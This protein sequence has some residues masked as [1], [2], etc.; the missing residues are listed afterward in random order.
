MTNSIRPQGPHPKHAARYKSQVAPLSSFKMSTTRKSDPWSGPPS[1]RILQSA[2]DQAAEG[3][4]VR[5]LPFTSSSSN[6]R[7]EADA[8]VNHPLILLARLFSLKTR[9]RPAAVGNLVEGTR[10]PRPQHLTAHV[11]LQFSRAFISQP[12]SSLPTPV[13]SRQNGLHV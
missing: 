12:P 1:Y 5:P 8:N 4:V 13:L 10:R 11:V 9:R 2:R 7:L 3:D 6:F